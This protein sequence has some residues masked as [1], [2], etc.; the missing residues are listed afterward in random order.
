[1]NRRSA[2]LLLASAAPAALIPLDARASAL[3]KLTVYRDPG[4][5]CCE[6]WVRHMQAAGF[7]V[8]IADDANLDARREALKVPASM[9]SCHIALADGFAFVGHIPSNDVVKFLIERPA[10][11]IGLA[12]PGMPAGSP[13]MGP[14][15][16]GG[17]YHVMLL[18]AAAAPAVY[19]TH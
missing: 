1:M 13:G 11:A 7:A 9:A 19:A 17:P 2:L 3:P 10:G 14:E 5:S 4:C 12:V 18:S 8:S 16:S 15:G 6:G